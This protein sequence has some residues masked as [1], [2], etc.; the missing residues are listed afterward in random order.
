M[1]DRREWIAA[2][3]AEICAE[4]GYPSTPPVVFEPSW[5]K[6]PISLDPF[7]FERPKEPEPLNPPQLF[8]SPEALDTLSERELMYRLTL[9][10]VSGAPRRIDYST[11]LGIPIAMTPPTL[12]FLVVVFLVWRFGWI[13]LLAL[14]AV[15]AV[16]PISLPLLMPLICSLIDAQ[17]LRD[18]LRTVDRT[19]DAVTGVAILGGGK[20]KRP[21]WMP[22]FVWPR[23][24][25]RDSRLASRLRREAD[26]RGYRTEALP[27][28]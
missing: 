20:R 5:R 3:A 24:E 28:A 7:K 9:A 17:T 10:L 11:K 2:R 1:E 19:G 16:I 22:Q 25:K 23:G 26:R 18:H 12:T 13:W 27:D 6:Q 14:P 21:D 8:V 15:F 4:L